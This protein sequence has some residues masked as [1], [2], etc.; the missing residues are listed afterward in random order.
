MKEKL[1]ETRLRIEE[2]FRERAERGG[3]A[4]LSRYDAGA[5]DVARRLYPRYQDHPDWPECLA[6]ILM[7]AAE[8]FH[9]RDDKERARDLRRKSD[10]GW[11]LRPDVIFGVYDLGLWG[12][13]LEDVGN[14]AEYLR[15]LG[16]SHLTV[17]PVLCA[18]DQAGGFWRGAQGFRDRGGE[19]PVILP[20]QS[21][22]RQLRAQGI[23]LGL[24]LALNHISEAHPWVSRAR[25]GDPYY[26][27]FF[28]TYPNR[29]VPDEV[30]AAL[31]ELGTDP[32][33][34]RFSFDP[35]LEAWV[36]TTFSPESWDLN[37]ANPWVFRQI[38]EEVLVLGNAG[39]EFLTLREL[40]FIWK[41]PGTSCQDLPEVPSIVGALVDLVRMAAPGMALIAGDGLGEVESS[42]YL[43]KA[44]LRI[45]NTERFGPALWTALG[46]E[47]G[48]WVRAAMEGQTE[49]KGFA[50]TASLL[51][52]GGLRWPFSSRMGA[53]FGLGMNQARRWMLE[54]YSGE[55]ERGFGRGGK[56]SGSGAMPE[57]TRLAGTAAAL[58]GLTD[59]PGDH[60]GDELALRRL[61]LLH[62]ILLSIGILPQL[63][64]GDEIGL[65]REEIQPDEAPGSGDTGRIARAPDMVEIMERRND[66]TKPEGRIYSRLRYLIGLRKQVAA[67]S[68]GKPEFI[69]AGGSSI[70]GYLRN[71]S[72]RSVLCLSNLSDQEQGVPAEALEMASLGDL[73]RDLV[74]GERVHANA[75]LLLA[76]YQ[77]V[78][79][80]GEEA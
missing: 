49:E 8:A 36:W 38:L 47:E 56:I 6:S 66:P 48:R 18:Y 80:M 1:A 43:A 32:N 17:A 59:V 21:A 55:T 61:L 9:D 15:D 42:R 53:R 64:I 25:Q 71:G 29:T 5:L 57:E 76:P 22:A 41:Q 70:L 7:S 4:F 37:Y 52:R 40:P 65:N 19:P 12:A 27:R 79:I 23:G 2:Y 20:L 60:P 16:I 33:P 34:G 77:F 28:L 44:G 78:W 3:D 58:V 31:R 75:D 67:F 72:A 69:H 45:A 39:V 54:F 73:V 11:H 46:R 50:W 10:T 24:D 68:A 13:R 26:R 14:R 62:S 63:A 51:N 30:E 35:T 74:T